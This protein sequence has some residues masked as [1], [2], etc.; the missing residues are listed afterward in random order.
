M[1]GIWGIVY[2]QP[3][4]LNKPLFNT[5]GIHNDTRGGDSCGIFVDSG[6]KRLEYGV[7]DFKLY[8]DFFLRSKILKEEEPINLALGHCRKASVGTISK[9]TAQPVIIRGFQNKI[10]FVLMHNGTIHN[11]E[12]LA[13]K[14][15]PKEK[16]KGL[17]DSQVMAKI[18]YKEGYDVLEEYNGTAVFVT[19]DYR[20]EKPIIRFFKGKSKLSEY[21]KALEDERPFYYIDTDE[22]I[23][24]SSLSSMMK[25]FYP[26][27]TVYTITP[28]ALCFYNKEEDGLYIEKKYDRKDCMQAKSWPSTYQ[29]NYY[30]ERGYCD[31]YQDYYKKDDNYYNKSINPH[32]K[33]NKDVKNDIKGLPFKSE[34][35]YEWN[36]V[37]G[38]V[39]WNFKEDTYVVTSGKNIRDYVVAHGIFSLNPNGDVSTTETADTHKMGFWKGYLLKHYELF[40][41][42][43]GLSKT[44]SLTPEDIFTNYSALLAYASYIPI[45]DLSFEKENFNLKPFYYES[46]DAEEC[47]ACTGRFI[48]PI[49]SL[50]RIYKNGF[51]METYSVIGGIKE[52]SRIFRV[53]ESK[54]NL[55]I[56]QDTMEISCAFINTDLETEDSFNEWKEL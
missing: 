54:L 21:R 44:F 27:S 20:G 4:P 41:T 42:L 38:N 24:F 31:W 50:E 32:Y 45:K 6:N 30:G 51:K 7:K 5:L 28:N 37:T 52:S 10:E 15:I 26:N 22:A 14:Y 8:E 29:N 16:I 43:E 34:S 18:F 53:E 46:F 55:K 40:N 48:Y 36:N 39:R 17:T 56:L 11:Y 1:C 2:K 9:E 35:E 3:Q 12:E 19:V 13:K 33:T 25:A 47:I 23:I 49:T